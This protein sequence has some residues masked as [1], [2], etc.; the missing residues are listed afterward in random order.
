MIPRQTP[1]IFGARDAGNLKEL[2][3]RIAAVKSIKK[4]TQTMKLVAASKLS[5]AQAKLESSRPYGETS[6][7]FMEKEYPRP[8]EA[9]PNTKE[10][11]ISEREVQEIQGLKGKHLIIAVTSDRGLCG[12]INSSVV[13]TAKKLISIAPDKTVLALIG[14]KA[15]AGLAQQYTDNFRLSIANVSGNTKTSY[16]ES[17]QIAEEIVKL[18]FDRATIVYNNF[19][20]VLAFATKK[21]TLPSRQSFLDQKKYLKYELEESREEILNDL[22]VFSLGNFI[23]QALVEAHASELASRMTSMDNATNNASDVIK[24]LSIVYNK[25]RQAAITTE[26]TEIVSGAAAIAEMTGDKDD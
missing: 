11:E 6:Q 18:D 2:R 21:R 3:T 16:T 12:G 7:R 25:Q 15:V 14:D 4:I 5:R 26:L 9:D 19:I 20:S 24:R 17:G 8:F 23:H 22:Y 10:P 13:R 1:V